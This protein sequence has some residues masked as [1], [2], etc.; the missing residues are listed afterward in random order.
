[1]AARGLDG[2]TISPPT[3]IKEKKT[4]NFILY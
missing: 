2:G 3:K 4:I 1:V